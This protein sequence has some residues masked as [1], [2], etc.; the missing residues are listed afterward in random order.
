M[1]VLFV[2]LAVCSIEKPGEKDLFVSFG[3]AE[4]NFQT[5]FPRLKIISFISLHI[6]AQLETFFCSTLS[7]AKTVGGFARLTT[8]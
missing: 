4:K 7:P 5:V 1:K 2:V 3:R 8:R 6:L